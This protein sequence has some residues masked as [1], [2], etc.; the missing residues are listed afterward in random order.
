MP[1]TRNMITTSRA[2][3]LSLALSAIVLLSERAEAYFDIDDCPEIMSEYEFEL[4]I[5]EGKFDY[6]AHS[7]VGGDLACVRLDGGSVLP[8]YINRTA[9]LNWHS[10]TNRYDVVELLLNWSISYPDAEDINGL[11]PLHWAAMG[12]S[13]EV[14]SLLLERGAE[15]NSTD[16]AGVTPLHYTSCNSNSYEIAVLFM[17][18]GA[19]IEA[20]SIYLSNN[21]KGGM[22]PLHY[23]AYCDNYQ[24]AE[25][26]L[27]RGAKADVVDNYG[28]T[29]AQWARHQEASFELVNLLESSD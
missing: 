2:I 27:D 25:L 24:I 29:P 10:Y 12:G 13:Y 18:H 9:A 15:V 6:R 4:A 1:T 28:L 17:Q 22:T 8:M 20:R 14:S 23:A 3:R 5:S 16:I 19:D 11:R 26:L 21:L 7:R